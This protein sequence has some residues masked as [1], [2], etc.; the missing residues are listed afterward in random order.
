M[1]LRI[2]T[3]ISLVVDEDAVRAVRAEDASGSFGIMPGHA[4]FLTS[5][6]T[7][8]VSWQ[9]NDGR[10]SYCAVRGGILTVNH[11]QEVAIASREAIAGDDLAALDQEVLRRFREDLEEQRK[12]RLDS[13][14][15]QVNAIR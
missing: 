11:G 12:S 1:R 3:P 5:L 10:R 7:S 9:R 4:D 14:R 8:V 13:M 6:A 2:T 15:L